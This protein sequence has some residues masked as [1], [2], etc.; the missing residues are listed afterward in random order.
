MRRQVGRKKH[1]KKTSAKTTIH[2]SIFHAM[3]QLIVL[4]WRMMR[5]FST[6]FQPNYAGFNI[7][8][9][10]A[11]MQSRARLF[12]VTLLTN[13]DGA[14]CCV[15]MNTNRTF[16]FSMYL[17]VCSLC[18]VMQ[19]LLPFAPANLIYISKFYK[20]V[21]ARMSSVAVA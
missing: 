10:Y 5:K 6:S 11:F 13:E 2:I 8:S 7:N 1:R 16:S 14:I 18:L 20:I 19:W 17:C 15:I 21:H 3:W 9:L 12:S 4:E